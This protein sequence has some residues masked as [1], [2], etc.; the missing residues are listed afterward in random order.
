MSQEQ[1]DAEDRLAREE[2]EREMARE[3]K[4]IRTLLAP[5]DK[6]INRL[7]PRT[8]RRLGSSLTKLHKAHTTRKRRLSQEREAKKLLSKQKA[9]ATRAF[10]KQTKEHALDAENKEVV[11]AFMDNNYPIELAVKVAR[12]RQDLQELDRSRRRKLRELQAEVAKL[13]EALTNADGSIE[14]VRIDVNAMLRR[15]IGRAHV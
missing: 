2:E 4:E 14:N 11:R 1:R 15:Q 7:S 3:A 12:D 13:E 9:R 6:E 10:N 5:I 8:R